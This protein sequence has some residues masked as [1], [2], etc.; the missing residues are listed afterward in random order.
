MSEKEKQVQLQRGMTWAGVNYA[1]GLNNLPEA[2]A[3]SAV[4]RKFGVLVDDGDKKNGSASKAD[5]FKPLDFEETM[6]RFEDNDFSD[7]VMRSMQF[8]Q[9]TVKQFRASGQTPSEFLKKLEAENKS[10]DLLPENFPMRHV[11]AKLGEQFD[12]VE[13]IQATSLED[14]IK[15]DGIAEASAKKALEYKR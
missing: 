5:D 13:K 3:N 7:E 8:H 12:S 15:L 9:E 2:A 11:F 4:K 14:L 1:P 6:E 10:K